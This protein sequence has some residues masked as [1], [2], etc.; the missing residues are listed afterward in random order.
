[1]GA[2]GLTVRAARLTGLTGLTVRAARLTVRAAGLTVAG[3]AAAARTRRRL[4]PT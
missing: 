2:A 4:G 3:P 1:V